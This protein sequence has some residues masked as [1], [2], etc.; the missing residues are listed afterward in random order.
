MSK[1][2][3]RHYLT[4]DN[5]GFYKTRECHLKCHAPEILAEVKQFIST[6]NLRPFNFNDSINYYLNDKTEQC[7]CVIC[8]KDVRYGY[9]CCSNTCKNKNV[10]TILDRTRKTLLKK[11]GSTSPLGSKEAKEKRKKTCLE[12]YGVEHPS[13][14][15]DI[16]E[17]IKQTNIETYKDETVRDKVAKA[18]IAANKDHKEEIVKK[19][20]QTIYEKT[21]EYT[22]LTKDTIKKTKETLLKQ[23]GVTNPFAIHDDTYEKAK[24]GAINFFK[25]ESKKQEYLIKRK[26]N[27]IDKYGSEEK[28]N[29]FRFNNS[30]DRII[31]QLRIVG[32]ND[33]IIKYEYS[34]L[35]NLT[36]M[37]DNDHEYEMSFR[38]I[39]DRLG[40]QEI[41]CSVCNPLLGHNTSI[42][43][44]ELYN[45]LS[46]YVNCEH[47]N[48]K[49]LEGK[50]LDIYVEDKKFA[51][52]YNGIYWHSDLRR[53]EDYHLYKTSLCKEKGIQLIHVWED[54][55]KNKKELVKNRILSKLNI[56]QTKIG[57]RECTIKEITNKEASMFFN[58]NH[59]QGAINASLYVA[60][61]K[62]EK[63]VSAICIGK[64]KIN[65]NKNEYYEILRFCNKAGI[66]CV[67]SF[68]KLFKYV[69]NKCPGQYIS[70]AD[71][72]WGEGKVYEKAGFELNGFSLPNY[73][74]FVNGVRYH[75]YRFNKQNL[76][77]MGYDR[78]KTEKQIMDEDVKALRVYDC[79]NAI[80]EYKYNEK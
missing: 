14:N 45:W 10:N 63:I 22:T 59:L 53:D 72:C 4:Y 38:L 24:Q 52:E 48:R 71:L 37:C 80:W 12:T 43:E 79:G 61:I 26:Q 33:R 30:K 49:I 56:G 46:N 50:H 67:G 3:Y 13:S 39:R 47:T 28:Y 36:C 25:D 44:L 9:E 65:K 68:S 58:E 32:F 60:L 77:K 74:Y 35:G 62:N 27:I 73:W 76:I 66:N 34:N 1:E 40:R 23:Y 42:Q 21:G 18:I 54:L 19:R 57:A 15:K 51:I 20:K 11:N 29:E 2:E 7:I 17:R 69:I 70:Y 41:C 8:G 31:D 64:R 6:Y 75:R 55:W 78:N 5:S 16:K